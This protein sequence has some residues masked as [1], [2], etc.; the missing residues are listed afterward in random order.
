MGWGDG[1]QGDSIDDLLDKHRP[2]LRGP[3]RARIHPGLGSGERGVQR[4]LSPKRV[5]FGAVLVVADLPVVLESI[6]A[7]ALTARVLSLPTVPIAHKVL[8]MESSTVVG[9]CTRALDGLTAGGRGA[10]GA[11]GF[12]VVVVAMRHAVV[13]VERLVGEGRLLG[14]SLVR[15]R[16]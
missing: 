4:V 16:L 2:P 7:V 8:G 14:D 15:S 10:E 3:R 13:D 12:G 9:D 5:S 1:S 11:V 6:G